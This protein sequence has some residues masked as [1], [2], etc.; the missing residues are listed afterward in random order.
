MS[1]RCATV[2]REAHASSISQAVSAGGFVSNTNGEGGEKPVLAEPIIADS[3]VCLT[4]EAHEELQFRNKFYSGRLHRSL[5]SQLG[6]CSTTN[7]FRSPMDQDTKHFQVE[8]SPDFTRVSTF[9][10]SLIYSRGYR[11]SPQNDTSAAPTPGSVR[12]TWTETR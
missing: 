4:Q 9:P 12:A 3:A 2:R 11:P 6:F 10:F 1:Q 5:Q 8:I 7:C